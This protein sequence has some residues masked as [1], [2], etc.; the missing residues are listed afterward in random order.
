[1]GDWQPMA[2]QHPALLK[3]GDIV[4]LKSGGPPMTVGEVRA[5]TARDVIP[6]AMCVWFDSS[7]QIQRDDFSIWLLEQI[8]VCRG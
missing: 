6:T 1:M 4:R 2:E 5:A 8:E 3:A 7:G